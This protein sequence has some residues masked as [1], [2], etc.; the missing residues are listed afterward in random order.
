MQR[1]LSY[2]FFGISLLGL[3]LNANAQESVEQLS[4]TEYLGY[5]KAFHPFVKQ[6]KI[7][8]DESEA[9]LMKARGA[10]DP[11]LGLDLNEKTFKNATYYD[12][13]NATFE[14]PTYYGVTIKG[15]FSEAEGNYLNP[16]NEVTGEGLYSLGAELNL[17]KGLLANE[18]MT[19]LRQA[20]LFTQQAEEENNLRVNEILFEAMEAYLDWYRAHKEFE[21]FGQF[22]ENARFRFDG[23][24][25][26]F[27]TGDLAA[28]DTTEARIAYNTRVLSLEK[29]QLKLREKALKAANFLWINDV[30]VELTENVV[31]FVDESS[32]ELRFTPQEILIENHPKLK[33]L[34]FKVETQ[35]L[36]R[37]LQRSNLLPEVTLGYQ[38]LSETDVTENIRLGL[39]PEN[40]TAKLKVGLPLFLRKERA[41]LE[42]SALKFQ[43]VSLEQE[44]VFIELSNKIEA[45]QTA[46]ESYNRQFAIAE[47]MV[48]DYSALFEGERQK[49]AAGESSLFLVN[50]RESKLI[51]GL[52]KAIELDIAEKVALS[53]LYFNTTF[54]N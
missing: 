23:V 46:V 24:K 18:R 34:G 36:E 15:G 49:F 25:A 10:F 37:R 47:I 41:E 40:N 5:V 50:T 51:E 35:R 22:V 44:R 30:P 9:K 43:E 3:T 42:L 21:V 53:E 12:R 17:A 1:T 4:L 48:G 19:T 11:K 52:L 26:R 32:Y 13:L 54:N 27:S 2:L 39:D 7:T 45:L 8:L 28:I 29:A 20:K 6:A 38:W 31:P 14:V 16:E 33:V